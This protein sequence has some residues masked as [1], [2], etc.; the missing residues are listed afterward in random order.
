MSGATHE[1]H[2]MDGFDTFTGTMAVV[3]CLMA[4]LVAFLLIFQK[5]VLHYGDVIW[6]W[7]DYVVTIL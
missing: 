1:D 6:V 5:P 3:A 2:G 7:L 4:F